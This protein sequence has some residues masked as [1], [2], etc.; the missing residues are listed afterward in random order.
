[1]VFTFLG[2]YLGIGRCPYVIQCGPDSSAH[3]PNDEEEDRATQRTCYTADHKT[4]PTY[5]ENR[6][7]EAQQRRITSSETDHHR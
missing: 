4:C 6:K 5:V 1:M 7:E 3:W 2:E